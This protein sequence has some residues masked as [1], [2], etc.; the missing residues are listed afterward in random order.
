MRSSV[1]EET[2]PI[3]RGA[4]RPGGR[5]GADRGGHG[6]G[7]AEARGAHDHGDAVQPGR[8]RTEVGDGHRVE[9][10]GVGADVE[11]RRGRPVGVVEG[12]VVPVHLHERTA[13]G[14]IDVVH[15][16]ASSVR[17]PVEVAGDVGRRSSA[18]GA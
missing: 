3:E 12:L 8:V 11:V 16:V 9:D 15:E 5:R 14:R 4:D 18:R 13:E 2:S 7:S 10:E 1:S 17:A 6:A